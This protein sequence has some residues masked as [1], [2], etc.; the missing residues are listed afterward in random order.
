MIRE[1]CCI[2][3]RDDAGRHFTQ[4]SEHY[5]ALEELGLIEIHRPVH[6]PSGIPYAQEHWSVEATED[7]QA[8]VDANPELF[9]AG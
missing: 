3:T 1:L 7:G 9:P 6:E 4:W 2:T 8:L 5:Q